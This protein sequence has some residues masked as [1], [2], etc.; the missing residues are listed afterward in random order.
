[1]IV[2]IV[3]IIIVFIIIVFIIIVNINVVQEWWVVA[4][5][6]NP[7]PTQSGCDRLR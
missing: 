1:M 6:R 4:C 2:F 3:F 5:M 7:N